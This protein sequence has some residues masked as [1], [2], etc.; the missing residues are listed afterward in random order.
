MTGLVGRLK[1]RELRLCLVLVL[2]T[3]LTALLGCGSAGSLYPG[4]TGQGEVVHLR[5]GEGML[6]VQMG[7]GEEILNAPPQRRWTA[8][9]GSML[10]CTSG[11]PAVVTDVV[12]STPVKPVSLWP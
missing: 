6:S 11:S 3:L 5:P 8:T 12:Y 4:G 1:A 9:F 10:L 7:A 2:V